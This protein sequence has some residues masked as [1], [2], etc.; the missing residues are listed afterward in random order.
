M[1]GRFK[2]A[3]MKTLFDETRLGNMTLKNRFIRAAV[4]EATVDGRVNE[5]M[6]QLYQKLARGG[7]GTLITGF[8]LVD[9]AEKNF[10]LLALYDDSFM[11]GHKALTGLVHEHGANIVLQLVYVGSYAMGKTTGMTVLA[12]SAVENANTKIMPQE[13]T[14][15]QIA[16]IQKKFAAAALRAKNAGYDGVELHAAHGFLLSQF[17]TPHYNRRTDCYGGSAQNRARMARETYAAVRESV[18]AAFPVLIKINV[19]D[20]IE[21]EV[22]FEDVLYLCDALTK[23]KIDAVEISGAF[24][25]FPQDAT[26]FF[27]KEAE[28][29]AARNDIKVILTG[30]NRDFAEMTEILNATKIEYFGMARPL[31]KEPD[32][33]N[34]F[35]KRCMT[36]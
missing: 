13:I 26:S 24:G 30:G 20:G 17:M 27:K 2:G 1:A 28:Q 35:G 19:N 16:A 29:I 8:T 25:T 6:L 5:A 34:R 9:E 12:P 23:A 14:V 21:N 4:G 10:P 33:I 18:G 32:L 3:S 22:R 11:E 15:P 31:I 36:G 7:A